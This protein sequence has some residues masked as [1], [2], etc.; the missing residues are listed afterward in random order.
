MSDDCLK[1]II[2]SMEKKLNNL[3]R[4]VFEQMKMNEKKNEKIE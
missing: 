1:K 3:Q 2:E 4:L